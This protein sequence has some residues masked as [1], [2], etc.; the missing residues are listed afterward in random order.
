LIVAPHWEAVLLENGLKHRK[1]IGLLGGAERLAAAQVAARKVGD[2]ERIAVAPIGE[3][4]LA[5]VIGAP[6]L[7]GG[8]GKEVFP[9]ALFLR[10][11]LRLTR[12]WR[13]R[14]GWTVLNRRRVRLRIGPDEL[15]P[16][17]RW[18]HSVACPAH[19]PRLDL[20]AQLVGMAIRLTR[21]GEAVEAD[22]AVAGKLVPAECFDV[23][24]TVR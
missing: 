10:A 23:G 1:S 21:V 22:R 3:H 20:D 7:V 13:S 12:P 11:I 6:Q 4:D 18:R 15:L 19:D 9:L 24:R 14:T 8:T 16:D 2:G 5:L 17:L